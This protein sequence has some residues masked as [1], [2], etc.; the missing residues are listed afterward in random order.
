MADFQ[1]LGKNGPAQWGPYGTDNLGS[2]DLYSVVSTNS[3][4][5]NTPGPW[6]EIIGSTE[7][8]T[9]G[10]LLGVTNNYGSRMVKLEI[11]IGASGSE[12]TLIPA[13]P[14]PRGTYSNNSSVYIP[15]YIP[16][17]SRLSLRTTS[18]S[19][20]GSSPWCGVWVTLFSDGLSNRPFYQNVVGPYGINMSDK[21]GIAPAQSTYDPDKNAWSELITSIDR[22]LRVLYLGFVQDGPEGGGS[23]SNQVAVDLAI[24]SS[25]GEEILVENIILGV[26][27]DIIGCNIIGPLFLSIPTA[28]RISVRIGKG[29][30][31]SGDLLISAW[32][33]C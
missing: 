3:S 8:P 13:M 17:G 31:F 1:G 15:L 28:S 30:Y 14:A 2:F 32:G 19:A 9:F 29:D 33:L 21:Y 24:G 26:T 25:G 20:T 22:N 18:E 7:R 23:D 5:A 4:S 6:V 12:K 10:M 11:G 16:Q 27:N